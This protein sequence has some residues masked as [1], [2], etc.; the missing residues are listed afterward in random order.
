MRTSK[1]DKSALR[2]VSAGSMPWERK[3]GF[4]GEHVEITPLV[5]ELVALVNTIETDSEAKAALSEFL[6][7]LEAVGVPELLAN[8]P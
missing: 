2:V 6:R 5:P 1:K 4:G 7:I 3:N 8:K